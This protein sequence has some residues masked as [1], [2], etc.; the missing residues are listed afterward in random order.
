MRRFLGY[1]L[2]LLTVSACSSLQIEDP[3]VVGMDPSLEGKTV[4]VSFSVPDVRLAPT[5]T[6]SLEDGDGFI[7][8]QP[9]LDPEKFYVV[10][11]GHS[12]SIKY[13]RKA[14]IVLDKTTGEPLIKTITPEYPVT[15]K[16]QDSPDTVNVY[17]FKVQLELSDSDRT[18]HFLGNVDENQLVTGSYSYQILPS[19]ISFEK[20]QAYWQKVYLEH[21]H[22][23][24]EEGSPVTDDHGSY[25][26]DDYTEQ[27]LEYIPLIRNY[28]KIQVTNA[29]APEDGFELHSYAVINFPRCGSVVPYRYNVSDPR[30]AFDFNVNYP[31]DRLSGY[32]RCDF[33]TLDTL[34]QYPGHI[35]SGVGI[36]KE[37]PTDDMFIN[38]KTS[39][40]RVILYDN[41]NPNQG[42]YIYERGTPTT[43]LE[44]TFVIIRGRFGDGPYYYYRLDLMET[45]MVDYESI[46]QYYP[47]YRN[48]R[49]NI[50]V[51]RI[52][53]Q[54][55]S[56]PEAA[57]N[58]SGA[59]DISA[60][61]SMRHL[62]DISNGQTRLVVEPF[63]A[64]TY[65][66]PSEDG[67][68]YLYAR[69]FNDLNSPVPNIDW[70]AVTVELETM[71]DLSDDILTL[72]DD[73]GHE[74]HG[75]GF[76]YPVAQEVGGEPGFRVIRFNTKEAGE[77]TKTQKIKITGR[78]QYTYEEFPLYREVEISL[79]KKQTMSLGLSHVDDLS[80]QKGAKQTLGIT[81][82]SGLPTSMFP[83]EFTIEAEDL[84][85][86]PD[87]EIAGNN[88]PVKAGISISDNPHYA[89]KTTFQFTRT[90][91]QEEYN[92][93]PVNEGFCTFY[94]YFKSNRS[95][96][97]TTI[98][99]GNEYFYK[100]SV[101]F[102]NRNEMTGH[103]YV[104][105]ESDEGC[106]VKINSSNLEYKLDDD[107]DW[108]SYS[109]N[110]AITLEHYHVVYFRSTTQ[111]LGWNG[112][113][114]FYCYKPGNTNATSRNGE[115]SVGGNI[116]SLIIGDE[117]KTEGENIS[118]AYSF[119]DFF[120]GHTGLI[121][122]SNLVLPMTKC[123]ANCYKSMFENCS[124]LSNVPLKLPATELATSCYESMFSGCTSIS[125]IPEGFLPATT[126]AKACYKAMFKGCNKLI[127]LPSNLLPAVEA[128]EQAY[129]QMFHSCSALITPPTTLPAKTLKKLCYYQMFCLCTALES[130]PDFPHDPDET[131]ILADGTSGDTNKQDGIC[132]QMFYACNALTTLEGKQLFNSSTTLGKFCFQDMFSTCA[133]LAT[134][135]NDFLPAMT[136]AESCYRGM[137]QQTPIT[138]A[139]DLL[140]PTLVKDC[141]RYMFYTCKSLIYIKCYSTSKGSTTYTQNWLNNARNSADAVFH[142]R[143][144]VTWDRNVHGVPSKWTLQPHDVQ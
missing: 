95:K 33:V 20:K 62:N 19:L 59:E 18:I 120:K 129:Y 39:D 76:F 115:F 26:P 12:Q 67:F 74:V 28:A 100:S 109:S 37:I 42:F 51:N 77:T 112:G 78:N 49:Y 7:T 117:F 141:Y 80:L 97:A 68:Y 1:I 66:G 127:A 22:P 13:I 71:D 38:P 99:V 89:G 72:Y 104:K 138:H 107:G 3:N 48:F 116:A 118:D 110:S 52:S 106:I 64:R 105:S 57:A 65:T 63:M 123:S 88:L 58:S 130:I 73:Q 137:F 113:N 29:T 50:Q 47:I 53:S 90:L 34:I 84:T 102:F 54:G 60:D 17:T 131:Y 101:T 15:E 86:T 44:P 16:G 136:L 140:A 4:T 98:W 70:G 9:Y 96:S 61:I 45:K 93:L 24:M 121:D 79:Q 10:V 91:T 2:I 126:L 55:V 46:A 87:N 6:K 108:K 25:L 81:I 144:G 92:S 122:A 94:S 69:F 14:E 125:G 132:F 128:E 56:K 23:K 5:A 142:Y 111:I 83:L 43:T 11:C 21:I 119:S 124:S 75:G 30:Q 41:N 85:L 134:V 36:D 40:G 31:A 114:K 135:P 82:P 35:P 103:F 8:G 143:S 139:P 133:K 27:R 32:E